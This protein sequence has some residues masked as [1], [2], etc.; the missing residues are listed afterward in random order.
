M[1]FVESPNLPENAEIVL[2][3]EKY[4]K[5]LGDKLKNIGLSPIFVPDN[6]CVD[7]RVSGHADLSAIHLGKNKLVL[8]AYLKGSGFAEKMQA[9]GMD[10]FFS[11]K[12]QGNS[13]PD[14]AGLNLCVCGNKL[15]YNP[16]S[17]DAAIVDKLTNGRDCERIAVKQGYSKCSVC[18]LDEN[19]IITSDEGIHREAVERGICSLK[20]RPGYIELP[21][22]DY[23]FIGGATFKLNRNALAF[24]GRLDNHPDKQNILDF[25]CLHNIEAVYIT[26]KQLFDIGSVIQIVEKQQLF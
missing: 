16:K 1:K 23:G 2:I 10:I 7:D 12:I 24:T 6:P 14:D 21:G 4:C 25:L 8:A 18:V 19:T 3:G 13:Y 15:I 22:F 11:D 17:A 20:I 5:I 26:E 9:L